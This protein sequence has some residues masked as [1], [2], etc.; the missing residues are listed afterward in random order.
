M[1]LKKEGLAKAKDIKIRIMENMELLLIQM[2]Q[3]GK[4]GSREDGGVTPSAR[5]L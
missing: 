5:R 2:N 4:F 3:E 1:D